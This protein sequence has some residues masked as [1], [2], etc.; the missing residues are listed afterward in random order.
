MSNDTNNRLD[1]VADIVSAYLSNNTLAAGDIAGLI[2]SVNSA[3]QNVATGKVEEAPVELKPAVPVKKSITPDAI[4]CL[5]DG[6]AFKSLKRHLMTKYGMTPAEYRAK[7]GLPKDYP[8]V[9]PN[10]AAA[11]SA[12]A[13]NMGL[14]LD[15]RKSEP[16]KAVRK[17]RKAKAD[18]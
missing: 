1:L 18:A 4:I 17:P 7:W 9:A 3:I 2:S 10:Y 15:R 6:K 12:L 11:R 13:R 14:G 5:E 16:E 8:M